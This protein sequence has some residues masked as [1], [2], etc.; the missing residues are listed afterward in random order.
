MENQ[1][2]A[3][4]PTKDS[5]KA[6]GEKTSPK[7]H[8]TNSYHIF[9]G[10]W[11]DSEID[12]ISLLAGIWRRRKLVLASV[13]M[14]LVLAI[15]YVSLA[16]PLYEVTLQVRPGITKYNGDESIR[17]WRISDIESWIDQER[18]LPLLDNRADLDDVLPKIRVKTKPQQESIT[19]SVLTA[20]PQETEKMLTEL[21]EAWVSYYV[22]EG[23]DSNIYLSLQLISSQLQS[24]REELSQIDEVEVKKVIMLIDDLKNQIASIENGIALIEQRRQTNLDAIQELKKQIDHTLAN[25]AKL[26]TLRDSVIAKQQKS[27][28]ALL[29]YTN[30][31]QQNIYHVT[32]LQE[33]AARTEREVVKD[34]EEKLKLL[35]TIEEKKKEIEDNRLVLEQTLP[36]ERSLLV[37]DIERLE[38]KRRILAPVELVT[39]PQASEYPVKP[40][41]LYVLVTAV[42]FGF[43]FGLMLAV[44]TTAWQLRPGRP[45]QG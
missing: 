26:A 33:R 38:E 23:N 28:L 5:E 24:A 6:V 4:N 2:S 14:A 44:L 34:D 11:G 22:R 41:K 36:N 1:L 20:R 40:R 39:R 27:D 31:I 3:D 18:Y 35:R 25:T 30:I 17:S 7:P 13:G 9:N 19:L 42:F 10:T 16:T 37:R 29:M 12:L 21:I 8:E 43:F 32:N 15:A 45:K